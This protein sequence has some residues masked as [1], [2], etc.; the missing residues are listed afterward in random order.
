MKRIAQVCL[1][2][3]TLTCVMGAGQNPQSVEGPPPNAVR[4]IT[5]KQMLKT[6]LKAR[7]PEEFRYIDEIVAFVDDGYLSKHMVLGTFFYARQQSGYIPL[8]Y[9]QQALQDRAR[10]DGKIVPGLQPGPGAKGF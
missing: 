2:L 5:L 7:R 3:G 4:K 1:L 10:K 9:F 8:P 6:G